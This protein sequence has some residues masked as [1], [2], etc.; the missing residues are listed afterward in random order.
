MCSSD[1]SLP[2]SI[3][4]APPSSL[5]LRPALC[6]PPFTYARPATLCPIAPLQK[7]THRVK[8]KLDYFKIILYLILV[9]HD[10]ARKVPA[11]KGGKCRTATA[12]Y[13]RRQK[14]K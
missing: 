8:K 9:L 11:R 10:S 12:P 5:Q 1:L 6:H 4:A 14:R 3:A 13:Y 2:F 7:N